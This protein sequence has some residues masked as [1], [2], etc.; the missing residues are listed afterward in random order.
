GE[1]IQSGNID[2]PEAFVTTVATRLAIDELR[3]ARRR[4]EEY[5]GPWLPEPIVQTDLNPVEL[6]DSLS[7][8]LMVVLDA[9]SPLE[10]A[11]FLLHDVFDFD[12]DEL[13]R[14][15]GRTPVACRQLA[16]RARRRVSDHQLAP[17]ADHTTHV[18]LLE[19]FLAAASGTDMNGLV[20]LLTDDVELVSDGGPN[21]KAARKPIVGKDRV[22]RF[23]RFVFPKIIEGQTAR[24]V[25]VNGGPGFVVEGADGVQL[26]GVVETTND[27]I[28][29]ILWILNPDKL[30]GS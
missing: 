5:V 12:Y 7:Y 24:I 15:L 1:P 23:L 22:A 30:S 2:N 16:S 28:R 8:A 19:R 27:R 14:V 11:T 25:A 3:S 26:V 29:R 20:E 18:D 9:L 10:R 6:A 13:A 4:R 17:S 21:R